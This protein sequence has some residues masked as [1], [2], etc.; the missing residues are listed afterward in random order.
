MVTAAVEAYPEETLGVLIGTK[1]IDT[2]MIQYAVS[3]QTAKRSKE[4]V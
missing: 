4:E 2:F 1:G 3:Y